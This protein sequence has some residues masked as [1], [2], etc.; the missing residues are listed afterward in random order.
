M[1]KEIKQVLDKNDAVFVIGLPESGRSYQVRIISKKNDWLVVDIPAEVEP[2]LEGFSGVIVVNSLD[3]ITNDK[4]MGIWRKLITFYHQNPGKVKFIFGQGCEEV[5]GAKELLGNFYLYYF[6]NRVWFDMGDDYWPL[7]KRLGEVEKLE[8]DR[9]VSTA[10]EVLWEC[11]AE[12]SQIQLMDLV[13]GKPKDFSDYLTKT[14]VVKNV[15]GKWKIFSPLFEDWLKNKLGES[16][17]VVEEKEGKLWLN[18]TINL[19]NDLSFQEYS[20][21]KELFD[22]K[23]ETVSR[24]QVA[25]IL[26]PKDTEEKYSDWAIDQ[27]MSKIRKKIGDIGEKKMIKTLKG[28]GFVFNQE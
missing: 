8:L 13:R 18:G 20:V 6:E 4:R 26:W 14:G 23:D 9:V 15:E 19:E 1:E 24:N 5:N 21:L 10:F 16:R 2:A 3:S 7:K 28:Q 27:I 12:G 22:K 17:G 25:E 11:L